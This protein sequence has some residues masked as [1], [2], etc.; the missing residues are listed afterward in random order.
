MDI[1]GARKFHV[2]SRSL[3]LIIPLVTLLVASGVLES[4]PAPAHRTGAHA[5]MAVQR[6]ETARAKEEAERAEARMKKNA[7]WAASDA[8]VQQLYRE[9]DTLSRLNERVIAHRSPSGARQAI[10]DPGDADGSTVNDIAG[11]GAGCN[12]ACQTVTGSGSASLRPASIPC[13]T[14]GG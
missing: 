7:E 11:H 5:G 2:S 10:D 14:R 12:V 8:R 6:E 4:P 13:G 9:I 3:T 1:A